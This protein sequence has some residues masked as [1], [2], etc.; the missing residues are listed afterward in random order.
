MLA[1]SII[2]LGV[3]SEL[4][5]R[6]FIDLYND[7][8]YKIG[9]DFSIFFVSVSDY[10]YEDEHTLQYQIEVHARLFDTLEFI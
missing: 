8:S 3:D 10:Y 9:R 1:L 7:S 5:N 6:S 2:F 4:T